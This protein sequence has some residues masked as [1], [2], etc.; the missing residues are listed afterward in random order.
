MPQELDPKDPKA[1][2]T[3]P[4]SEAVSDAEPCRT[5]PLVA[6]FSI[7]LKKDRLCQ[8]ALSFG[9]QYLCRHP[10]HESFMARSSQK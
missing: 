5:S 9:H 3:Q 8:H 6:N 2:L 7:C 10:D 4:D 1:T